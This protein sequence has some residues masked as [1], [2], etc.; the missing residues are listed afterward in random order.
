VR[1]DCSCRNPDG[2]LHGNDLSVRGPLNP[3]S[4]CGEMITCSPACIVPDAICHSGKGRVCLCVC[5]LSMS[6]RSSLKGIQAT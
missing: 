5:S 3:A 6:T 4:L 2:K 1:N